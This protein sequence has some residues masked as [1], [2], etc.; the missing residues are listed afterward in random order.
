MTGAF[1]SSFC[2]YA[3]ALNILNELEDD[4]TGVIYEAAPLARQREGVLEDVRGNPN[5]NA[6]F[7]TTFLESSNLLH[8]Q[9]EHVLSQL[10]ARVFAP[11]RDNQ[12]ALPLG[13]V[14]EVRARAL[15]CDLCAI[16]TDSRLWR[17][18]GTGGENDFSSGDIHEP[19]PTDFCFLFPTWPQYKTMW[20]N[21]YSTP[22]ELYVLVTP[23]P[24]AQPP[25]N[26][27]DCLWDR[28]RDLRTLCCLDREYSIWQTVPAL[29]DFHQIKNKWLPPFRSNANYLQELGK[30]LSTS[31]MLIDIARQQIISVPTLVNV[32][33]AALSYVWGAARTSEQWCQEI[34]QRHDT[35]QT[36][37]NIDRKLLPLT[38]CDSLEICEQLAIPFLWI[39]SLCI[40]QN[41]S[42][43]KANT[44]SDM[45]HIYR[46]S[47]VCIVA[48][49]DGS[50]HDSLPGIREPRTPVVI[51]LTDCKIAI[52]PPPLCETVQKSKWNSRGWCFQESTLAPRSLVILKDQIFL[53]AGRSILCEAVKVDIG[54]NYDI[55]EQDYKEE[56]LT[57]LGL[58]DNAAPGMAFSVYK[59]MVVIYSKRDLSF[60]A[61]AE[62]AFKGLVLALE[63]RFALHIYEGLPTQYFVQA[64]NWFCT[65]TKTRSCPNPG[66]RRRLSTSGKPFAASWSWLSRVGAV[67]YTSIPLSHSTC[68]APGLQNLQP[69][70]T[71]ELPADGFELL[72]ATADLT[73]PIFT[74]KLKS[75]LVLRANLYHASQ[76][77]PSPFD[78]SVEEWLDDVTQRRYILDSG[79]RSSLIGT[80]FIVPLVH[81]YS[82]RSPYQDNVTNGLDRIGA[83]LIVEL[84]HYPY[85]VQDSTGWL[86]L[87]DSAQ[88]TQRAEVVTNALSFNVNG[89]EIYL[90]RRVGIVP[91]GLTQLK[92]NA[93]EH[94]IRTV[95]LA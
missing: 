2:D 87:C 78:V 59:D 29:A 58:Y 9:D 71:V 81:H 5:H 50:V 27:D 53:Q 13:T 54:N 90:A 1:L 62:D 64:L 23:L 52:S 19:K 75:T 3:R 33:Y 12:F 93:K 95:I 63:K 56:P 57:T 38:I 40:A 43:Q 85:A 15:T 60:E 73:H 84:F 42:I 16:F 24:D 10:E 92:I 37:V 32:Q 18:L 26:I 8:D 74:R 46:G 65:N 6:K 47:Y 88:P 89:S 17:F 91:Y 67:S 69:N 80:P 14:R 25:E 70:T 41:Q 77:S 86:Q 82:E 49:A 61:D 28:S 55:P 34:Q 79:N 44:I 45:G 76:V 21:Y 83:A 22:N 11:M 72:F 20:Y 68:V 36:T 35:A 51:Q 48:A 94:T 4:P 7:L 39:D 31:F 66:S 30:P